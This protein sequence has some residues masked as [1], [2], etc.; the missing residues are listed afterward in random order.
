ML[1]SF[2]RFTREKHGEED[3]ER[4]HRIIQMIGKKLIYCQDT[5]CE[6]AYVNQRD[7]QCC[8]GKNID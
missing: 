7:T 2:T 6:A 5:I 1:K 3:L 4:G 8:D